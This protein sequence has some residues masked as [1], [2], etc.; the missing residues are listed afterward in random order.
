MIIANDIHKESFKVMEHK[1][2]IFNPFQIRCPQ[3]KKL[4]EVTFEELQFND[5]LN[6]LNCENVFTANIDA[7]ALLMLVRKTEEMLSK[8]ASEAKTIKKK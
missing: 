6:C 5:K 3:C 8:D 2:L 4:V 7:K 1:D